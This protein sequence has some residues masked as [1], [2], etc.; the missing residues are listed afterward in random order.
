MLWH[1]SSY[2]RQN[3]PHSH[4]QCLFWLLDHIATFLGNREFLFTPCLERLFN[5]WNKDVHWMNYWVHTAGRHEA[6][7]ILRTVYAAFFYCYQFDAM[8]CMLYE[9]VLARMISLQGIRVTMTMDY[10]LRLW[11]LCTSIQFSPLRPPLMQLNTRKHS[12]F[13]PPSH[14]DD[15]GAWPSLKGSTSTWHLMW[16]PQGHQ[17]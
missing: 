1:L 9:I 10:H 2:W 17:R 12:T 7:F 8:T 14:P 3:F 13:S 15:P 6:T 5:L 11:G 16:C 4:F